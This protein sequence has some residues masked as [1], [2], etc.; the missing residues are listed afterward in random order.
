MPVRPFARNQS[1]VRDLPIGHQFADKARCMRA[2]VVAYIRFLVISATLILAQ[3]PAQRA[4]ADPF[5]K[6]TTS[7]KDTTSDAVKEHPDW[8]TEQ[9]IKY[10]PCPASVGFRNGRRACLGCPS[11]CRWHF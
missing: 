5:A 10:H 9:G 8:F 11:A 1:C 3:A 7:T 2:V 6:D 4:F